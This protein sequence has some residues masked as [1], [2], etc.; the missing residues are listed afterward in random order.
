MRLYV[1]GS[2]PKSTA[3]IANLKQLCKRH[4]DG[5]YRLEVIDLLKDPTLAHEDDILAIPTVVRRLPQPMRMVVGD[6]ADSNRV[7]VALD[8]SK[9]VGPRKRYKVS[10]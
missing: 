2:T 1:A 3:A 4:L 7:L 9:R 6:L 10:K 8:L 5:K